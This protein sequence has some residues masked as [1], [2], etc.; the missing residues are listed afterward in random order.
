LYR[1]NGFFRRTLGIK[2]VPSAETLRQRLD[3]TVGQ[4]GRILKEAN[5]GL[6][7]TATLTPVK[8]E[9]GE[10]VPVDMD[11]SPFDNSRTQ[12]E[13]WDGRTRG[14]MGTRRTLPMW[15]RKDIW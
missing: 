14:W 1:T 5:A 4:F 15:E 3:G 12:K 8:T 10:Y 2:R 13:G 7:S 6:L 11:V 9:L